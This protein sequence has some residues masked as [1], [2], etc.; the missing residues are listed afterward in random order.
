V[1]NLALPLAKINTRIEPNAGIEE[2]AWMWAR[3]KP[4]FIASP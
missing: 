4:V 1:Y 2:N 3:K